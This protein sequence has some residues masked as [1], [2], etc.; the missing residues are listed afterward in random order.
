M[1]IKRYVQ[2]QLGSIS[3]SYPSKI[4]HK[5]NIP[6]SVVSTV[7]N[8]RRYYAPFSRKRVHSYC[9][10]VDISIYT[11]T[12]IKQSILTKGRVKIRRPYSIQYAS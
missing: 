2:I 10:A 12:R 4:A 5:Q 8:V 11:A 6:T 9:L 3:Q 1:G 7:Y